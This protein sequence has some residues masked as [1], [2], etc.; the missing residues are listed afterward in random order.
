[1]GA[2]RVT[3]MDGEGK[4]MVE[5]CGCW[6]VPVLMLTLWAL[7]GMVWRRRHG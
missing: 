3:D 2:G 4:V 6:M 5:A 7:A 1:M